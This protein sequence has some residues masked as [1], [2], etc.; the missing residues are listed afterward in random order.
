MRSLGSDTRNGM[1][2]LLALHARNHKKSLRK[3]RFG[4][5]QKSAQKKSRKSLKKY[6]PPKIRKSVFLGTFLQTPIKTLFETFF[7]I[8][9]PEG[10]ET[11][12]N[13]GS[14]RNASSNSRNSIS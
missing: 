12:V 8:S 3:S 10:Q 4:N 14:G 7:A 1:R 2:D 5:L 6:P 9:G 11:P 13:V